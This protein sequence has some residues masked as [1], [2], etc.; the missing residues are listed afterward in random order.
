[1]QNY[2]IRY[3]S[4]E[5]MKEIYEDSSVRHFPAN[6]RKPFKAIVRM[7][8]AGCYEGL[9]LFDEKT[10]IAYAFY[11]QTPDKE[12]SLLDYY[13]VMEEYRG[14]GVGSAFLGMMKEWYKSSRCII[15][16]TEDLSMAADEEELEI[17][18]RRNS[19]YLRNGV[20]ETDIHV[21]YFD[22][23]YQIFY[24]PVSGKMTREQV[25]ED[26]KKIYRVMFLDKMEEL[27]RYREV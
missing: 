20:V 18:R 19:F 9:G 22:A 6:E 13:A 12:I 24:L 23:D 25:L 5:E 14:I 7:H 11:V 15:L 27:I 16:E 4:L 1:M 8:E 2:Q 3:L 26:L 21:S 10:L 17:R